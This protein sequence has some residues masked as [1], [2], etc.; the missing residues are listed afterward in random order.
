VSEVNEI[1]KLLLVDALE[2][3]EGIFKGFGKKKKEV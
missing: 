2:S 1:L 3:W